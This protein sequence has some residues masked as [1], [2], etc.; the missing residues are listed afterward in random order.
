MIFYHDFHLLSLRKLG[1]QFAEHLLCI[2][3]PGDKEHE[4]RRL[5]RNIPSES[6]H[7]FLKPVRLYGHHSLI[8]VPDESDFLY[9]TVKPLLRDIGPFFLL[10]IRPSLVEEH[11]SDAYEQ[12]DI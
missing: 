9:V 6:R 8:L 3:M 7:I 11:P 10:R 5:F 12:Y 4:M 1:V 2:E